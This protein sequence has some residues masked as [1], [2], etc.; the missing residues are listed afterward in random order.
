MLRRAEEEP[1]GLT[2]K[3]PRDSGLMGGR[4]MV[5]NTTLMRP[6]VPRDAFQHM[7]LDRGER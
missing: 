5:R 2:S 1:P 4:R 6:A 3:I 7:A